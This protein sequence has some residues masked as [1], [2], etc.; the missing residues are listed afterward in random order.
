MRPVIYFDPFDSE[1]QDYKSFIELFM[2]FSALA[3]TKMLIPG[4]SD[5][6]ILVVDMSYRYFKDTLVVSKIV[7][8]R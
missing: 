1:E 2:L 4:I 6:F 5:A 8:S 7:N 3:Y